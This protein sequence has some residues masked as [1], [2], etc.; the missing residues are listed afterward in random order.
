MKPAAILCAVIVLLGVASALT[1]PPNLERNNPGILSGASIDSTVSAILRRSCADCH[2]DETRYPWYSYVAPVSWWLRRHVD[3]GR[4]HLNLSR[5]RDYPAV[6]RQRLLS[7]IAS[8][9][10]DREMPIPQYTLLH[11]QARLSEADIA[12]LFRWTQ[13][14]RARLITEAWA[15]Q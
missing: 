14:E 6:R 13:E 5:W 9:V 10:R 8:Q 12:A 11:W 4:L 1:R 7:D 2:S 3:E 15:G